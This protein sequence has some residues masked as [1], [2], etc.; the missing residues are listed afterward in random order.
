MSCGLYVNSWSVLASPPA[1]I[2]LTPVTTCEVTHTNMSHWHTQ[3]DRCQCVSPIFKCLDN[4]QKDRVG[5][6]LSWHKDLEKYSGLICFSA[7]LC[8]PPIN[9]TFFPLLLQFLTNSF[10]DALSLSR[11]VFTLVPCLPNVVQPRASVSLEADAAYPWG[12]GNSI[13]ENQ[14]FEFSTKYLIMVVNYS[15]VTAGTQRRGNVTK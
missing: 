14:A 7:P 2:F 13:G 12:I 1:V 6:M 8:I 3:T 15:G 5:Q 4:T 10:S 9:A 11:R